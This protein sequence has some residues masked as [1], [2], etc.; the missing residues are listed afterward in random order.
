M[1]LVLRLILFS[2]IRAF[3]YD[4][5]LLRKQSGAGTLLLFID[6]IIFLA[7]NIRVNIMTLVGKM[8]FGADLEQKN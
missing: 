2:S 8:V 6:G 5:L 7:I 4:L 3:N 1:H